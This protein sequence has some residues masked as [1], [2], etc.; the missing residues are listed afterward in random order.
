MRRLLTAVV[1]LLLAGRG[2]SA[3]AADNPI[4]DELTKQ[5]ISDGTTAEKL[6]PPV[7]AS[8]LDAAAQRKVIDSI[9]EPGK[10]YEELVRRSVNAPF[11][12]KINE[13]KG[14]LK[15]VDAYFIVYGKLDKLL[16][17]GFRKVGK[18]GPANPPKEE[19]LKADAIPL[20]EK[21]LAARGIKTVGDNENVV[22]SY[23][24][25][26]D[27]IRLYATLRS[28]DVRDDDAVLL[29]AKIDERFNKD[30]KYPNYWQ[31][32]TRN[33][34][35]DLKVDA[36]K[37]PYSAAG[38]Y[39]KATQLKEPQDAIFV[40]YHLVFNEPQGWF[41][42]ARLLTSKLPIAAQQNIR[43]LRQQLE[44]EAAGNKK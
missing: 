7:M 28:F 22:H 5:G 19:A 43:K 8:G 21:T 23:A 16:E 10:G 31:S 35:G 36:T 11:I 27:R 18:K 2:L 4:Y 39:A 42:G 13:G 29:A 1:V 37:H 9:A 33:D 6:A 44:E 20:D 15:R 14:T 25:I 17:D 38:A 26:F 32:L 3:H 12:L 24:P 41:N 40:E 34:A 30:E